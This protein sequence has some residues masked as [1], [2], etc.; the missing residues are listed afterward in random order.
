MVTSPH[1][2]FQGP[3]QDRGCQVSQ[4]EE[5]IM[6]VH[7]IDTFSGSSTG[8]WVFTGVS[9]SSKANY[10]SSRFSRLCST[11]LP[12]RSVR[13]LPSL[14]MEVGWQ[15][16][17]ERR[18]SMSHYSCERFGQM[19]NHRC[20]FEKAEALWQLRQGDSRR[21]NKKM[22]AYGSRYNTACLLC[23]LEP[24]FGIMCTLLAHRCLACA[25][26]L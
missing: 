17:G 21:T 19:K 22:I 4:P 13:C 7:G 1:S 15:S 6:K 9:V 11:R 24:A 3:R 23:P 18:L 14:W 20:C 2:Y 5:R 16:F 25:V 12:Q 26:A 10:Y 8:L